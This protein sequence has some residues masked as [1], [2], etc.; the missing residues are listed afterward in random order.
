MSVAPLRARTFTGLCLFGALWLGGCG[1]GATPVPPDVSRQP[2]VAPAPALAGSGVNDVA[3]EGVPPAGAPPPANGAGDG[4]GDPKANAAAPLAARAFVFVE[5]LADQFSIQ[6]L[7]RAQDRDGKSWAAAGHVLRLPPG[8]HDVD[9][10]PDSGFVPDLAGV[11]MAKTFA[12]G[13]HD[14]TLRFE[15]TRPGSSSVDLAF[16]LMPEA[17]EVRVIATVKNEMA[18]DV[19]GFEP[20]QRDTKEPMGTVL[21]TRKLAAGA[22]IGPFTVRLSGLPPIGQTAKRPAGSKP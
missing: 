10:A 20:T 14:H 16:E 9:I 2:D 15:L 5:T 4:V 12:P 11:R 8:F 17:T 6:V 3:A 7:V 22:P 21:V 19:P 18:L 1:K 13:S